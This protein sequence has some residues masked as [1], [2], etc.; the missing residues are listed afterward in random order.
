MKIE[1]GPDSQ[2]RYLLE[3]ALAKALHTA[4]LEVLLVLF[5]R[6]EGMLQLLHKRLNGAT[7]H[8]AL[9]TPNVQKRYSRLNEVRG[10]IS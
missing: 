5:H 1:I 10:D 2:H 9:D 6:L 3:G 7:I 4:S 8:L